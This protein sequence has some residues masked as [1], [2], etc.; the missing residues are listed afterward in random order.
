MA[1]INKSFLIFIS[2]LLIATIGCGKY[3]SPKPPENLA[4]GSVRLFTASASFDGVE[5][6][7][8]PPSTKATGDALND[9]NT[10]LVKRTLLKDGKIVSQRPIAEIRYDFTAGQSGLEKQLVYKDR[11]VRPGQ[12]YEYSVFAINDDGQSGLPGPIVRVTF[13]GE[14]SP[15]EVY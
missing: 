4:P 10:F 3:G 2:F 13:R 5:L 9:L 6:S 1:I 7:W 11:A 12:V 15:I 14:A 8:I